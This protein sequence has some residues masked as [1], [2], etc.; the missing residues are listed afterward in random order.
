MAANLN[1]ILVEGVHKIFREHASRAFVS[2]IL[3]LAAVGAAMSVMLISPAQAELREQ[4]FPV[5]VAERADSARC[6]YP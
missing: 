3:V 6:W 4:S 1:N 5:K 2:R